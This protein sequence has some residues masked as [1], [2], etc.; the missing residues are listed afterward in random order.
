MQRI[1]S[2]FDNVPA[3]ERTVEAARRC[4]HRFHVPDVRHVPVFEGLVERGGLAEH[5]RHVPDL[6]HVP[7]FYGMVEIFRVAEHT[8]HRGHVRC[9]PRFKAVE[10]FALRPEEQL[11]HV[12]YERGIY[13]AEGGH[14]FPEA[15]S[16]PSYRLAY[17]FLLISSLL[18]FT[19]LQ[20]AAA[21]VVKTHLNV[22]YLPALSRPFHQKAVFA[23]GSARL[24]RV[25]PEFV[26]RYLLRVCDTDS[27]IR[28]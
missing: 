24:V 1:F 20:A 5:M 12:R 8:L 9:V 3:F 25:E 10:V 21:P 28:S 16:V 19:V 22:I 11:S 27:R 7:A 14:P 6:R 2:A 26:F 13:I 23:L 17:T 15:P 18:S 4:K